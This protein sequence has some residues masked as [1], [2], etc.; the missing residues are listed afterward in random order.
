[1]PTIDFGHLLYSPTYAVFGSSAILRVYG[2]ATMY[3]V[4]VI[5]KTAGVEVTDLNTGLS[6]LQPAAVVRAA[7]LDALGLLKSQLRRGTLE[8][9][10]KTWRIEATAPRATPAGEA[11]GEILLHLTENT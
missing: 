5:D 10:S 2:S 8:L 7:D 3:L 1:M 11:D 4:N 9:N 6:T